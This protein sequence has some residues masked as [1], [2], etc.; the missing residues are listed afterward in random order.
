[1]AEQSKVELQQHSQEEKQ[2][3]MTQQLSKERAELE[4]EKVRWG[5]HLQ[6]LST[7]AMSLTGAALRCV[8]EERAGCWAVASFLCPLLPQSHTWSHTAL[9]SE[10]PSGTQMQEASPRGTGSV[11]DA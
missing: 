9:Q 1:M 3:G 6:V 2:Q 5:R 8:V 11:H 7:C 10:Q 4:R